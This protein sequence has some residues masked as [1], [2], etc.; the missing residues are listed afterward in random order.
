V[1]ERE[2][3]DSMKQ[4][5]QVSLTNAIRGR[6]N[7]AGDRDC[8]EFRA[9]RGE[10]VAF[11]AATRSLGSGCDA[12]IELHA[13]DGKRLARSNPSA[14][15]EGVLIWTFASNGVYRLTVEEAAGASG[16]EMQYEIRAQPAAGFALRLEADVVN[17]PPGGTF[18][19]KGNVVR[20]DYKGPVTV[21]LEGLPTGFI[22]ASNSVAE[23]KTNLALRVTA[24]ETLVPGTWQTFS[25][26]GVA[27]RDGKEVRVE[28]STAPAW[29]R[30][31]P[32]RLHPP[33]EF[34]GEVTLGVVAP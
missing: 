18:D 32:L 16:P 8:F 13:A 10:R 19:L 9:T 3:N 30:Q 31:M 15:D 6:F 1:Q 24:P 25:I 27:K 2:P 12:F 20:G 33:P 4:A 22:V 14:A 17:V 26:A 23:G 29:R 28:A 34:D 5:T 11:R 7:R 21:A